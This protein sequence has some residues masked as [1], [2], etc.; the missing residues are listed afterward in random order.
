MK[1]SCELK[2]VKTE[3]YLIGRTAR[4]YDLFAGSRRRARRVL[5]SPVIFLEKYIFSGG[6]A[7]ESNLRGLIPALLNQ[8][9]F[10]KVAVI[11]RD[12]HLLEYILAE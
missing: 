8:A 2:D 11:K 3:G 10:T 5:V 12:F 7:L 4:F 6:D 1:I 9:R